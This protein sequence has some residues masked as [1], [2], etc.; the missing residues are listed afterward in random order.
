LHRLLA[1]DGTLFVHIDDNELGYLIVLLDSIFGRSNRLYVITFKQGSATGHKSINPGCVS[2]TNFILMYAKEKGL[3][4]PNRVFT[5]RE[6]DTRYGQFIENIQDDYQQWRIIT[7]TQAFARQL[8]VTD[9]EARRLIRDQPEQLDAFVVE[10]AQSV[11][12]TARPD[13][14][15]VGEAARQ[16]IDASKA[17]PHLM[18]KLARESHSD[19]YFK[20]G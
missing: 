13:Y 4:K 3:W 20:G 15:S 14:D 6:R 9:R 17:Q 1:R 8:G 16:A 7:L 10:N 12:R 19:M 11:V 18:L 5:G 2:T